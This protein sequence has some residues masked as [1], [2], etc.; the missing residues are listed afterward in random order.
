M[1][2]TSTSHAA[3]HENQDPFERLYQQQDDPWDYYSVAEQ[4][5]YAQMSDT[6]KRL[7]PAPCRVLD[8][9]CS[10]GY[11]TEMM[12]DY[13]PEVLAF[14]ISKRAVQRTRQRCAAVRTTTRFHIE[15]GDAIRPHYSPASIDVVFLG[16]VVRILPSI[17]D[18]HLAIRNA[19]ALLTDNGILVLTDCMKCKE[20]AAYVSLVESEGGRVQ[21]KIYYNDR[22]W[23][24]FRSLIKRIG[25]PRQIQMLLR[26]T[27]IHRWLCKLA[28]QRGPAGSKHFGLVVKRRSHDA[29][30]A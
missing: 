24:K 25:S 26:N 4:A 16:D 22:Y 7:C 19:L 15:L 13:S 18:Q 5:K 29:R 20:Q 30:A 9:A 12:A 3:R 28:S 14:D 21:E 8:A 17:D 1:L 27:T 2:E 11:L 23:I 6:A 10:L